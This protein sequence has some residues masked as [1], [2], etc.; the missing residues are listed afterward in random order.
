MLIKLHVSWRPFLGNRSI[1]R[2]HEKPKP[3]SG[4]SFFTRIVVFDWEFVVLEMENPFWEIIPPP[5]RL[6]GNRKPFFFWEIRKTLAWESI[7]HSFLGILF[8]SRSCFY[9]DTA[10]ISPPKSPSAEVAAISV[11]I[12]ARSSASSLFSKPHLS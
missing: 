9:C 5:H 7:P 1:S 10:I 6:M 8:I 3:L 12:S 4:N 2:S 11:L